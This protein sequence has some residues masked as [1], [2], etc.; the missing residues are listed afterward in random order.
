[1]ELN[2]KKIWMIVFAVIAIIFLSIT[3]KMVEYVDNSEVVVIQG[4]GG[5]IRVVKEAGPAWQGFGTAT[6]YKKSNQLWFSKLKH[7]GDT[8]DQSIKVRFNDGGH[9]NISG[10][11]RWYMP[12]DDKSIIKLH[13]DFSCQESVEAQLIKQAL[14]KSIYMSG[15]LMSSKESAA[16]KRNVLL[17]YIEDQAIGG[18]YV[19]KQEKMKDSLQDKF[20]TI[21]LLDAKGMPKR[22]DEE[23]L[24]K[25]Y[26]VRIEGLVI[27]SID[28][29]VDVE[30]QIKQQQQLTMAVQ[31]SIANA[32]K[33]TQDAIT[34]AKQG[35]ASAASAK[36]AQEVI[37]AKM[38]TEAQQKKEVAAL[39][40]QTAIEYAK[41]VKTESDA[42][43]YRNR[44]LV[45]AGLTPQE[46]AQF[47]MDTQIGVA[48]AFSK[49]TLPS[50]Y[51]VGGGNGKSGDVLQQIMSMMMLQQAKK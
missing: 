48:E 39:E 1:M 23:S 33:S 2:S 16:E 49:M 15:P 10:S 17:T 19:T 11:I 27:N 40:A 31:T 34:I 50:T 18:I 42:D 13:T 14:T 5:G 51:I 37:K 26:F 30:K 24:L 21:I 44:M 25:K 22:N 29:D 35:E 46:K 47:N 9:G 4:V 28:Y 43:S 38:I 3:P 8:S 7:E 45:S 36:W 41:K 32:Q 20:Q 6:H 12:S